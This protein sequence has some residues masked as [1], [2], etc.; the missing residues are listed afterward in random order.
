MEKISA[1]VI[2][3]NTGPP[4]VNHVITYDPTNGKL[5]SLE[6]DNGDTD[7]LRL[8]GVIVPGYIN[9]HCHLE[10]SHL[11][12]AIPTGTGLIPF[13]KA[14][15]QLRAYP[16]D[17]ILAAINAGDQEM[18]DNGIVAVGDISNKA[19]TV[20][21]KNNSHVKYHT[22][23][24]MF[25]L[26]Q[27]AMTKEAIKTYREVFALHSSSQGNKKSYVPHAP[28]S[29]S[30][31]IYGFINRSNKEGAT[32]S[33]HNQELAAENEFFLSKTG[34][35][36]G[37]Y[38]D[39][40]LGLENIRP[41]GTNSLAYAIHRMDPSHKTLFVHNTMSTTHDIK[42]AQAWNPNTYWATCPNANL[43]IENKLP[44]YQKFI[45]AGATMCIGT[46]SL[47][48]NWQLSIYEEMRTIK[49]Y[50][51]QINDI[52]IIKWATVNGADALGYSDLGKLAV[53]STPGLN[54]IDVPVRDGVFDLRDSL[55][56]YRII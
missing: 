51:S 47:S 12:N 25:D 32:V 22:F 28:Y 42:L 30:D 45:E 2:V 4:L 26:F 1:D 18:Y 33:I 24:E 9:A 27:P 53:G 35:M 49:K 56:S 36:V 6:A 10:L 48:S 20:A 46:D 5:C 44:E 43:Y 41:S 13:I 16:L 37:F 7:V 19:H 17:E 29:V 38:N 52:D 23:V 55:A 34:A 31:S 21:V 3:T 50:Q 40:G 54:H 14:I 8:R 11:K 39:M 15:L